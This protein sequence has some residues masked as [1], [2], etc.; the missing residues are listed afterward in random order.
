MEEQAEKRRVARAPQRFAVT[1]AP[2]RG[3]GAQAGETVDIS[4]QGVSV[5]TPSAWRVG[6]L[7]RLLVTGAPSSADAR[8]ARCTPRGDQHLLGLEFIGAAPR[9]PNARPAAEP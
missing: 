5:L 1:L 3:G 9:W 6:E 4:S 2:L 8:V 7:V